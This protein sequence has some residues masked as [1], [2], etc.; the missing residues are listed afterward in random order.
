MTVITVN[1]SIGH[2]SCNHSFRTRGIDF[3]FPDHC[4]RNG[5]DVGSRVRALDL[6]WDEVWKFTR[7]VRGHLRASVRLRYPGLNALPDLCFRRL[8][9]VRAARRQWIG[10]LR[11]VSARAK[12]E[13]GRFPRCTASTFQC[14][15]RYMAGK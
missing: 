7:I 13:I 3:G 4:A 11:Q 2:E 1:G 8:T 14:L 9:I 6:L 15:V 12:S 5:L 10:A